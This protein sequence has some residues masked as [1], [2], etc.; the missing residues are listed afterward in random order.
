MNLDGAR[1][2][3]TGAA[4]GIGYQ[5][6]L[7][8]SSKG[9]SILL[10]DRNREML[11]KLHNEIEQKNGK[12][13]VMVADLTN[14]A[15]R[16]KVSTEAAHSFGGVDILINNAGLLNFN[17][18]ATEDPAATER[19]LN[20][21]ITAPILLTQS[22]L[23]A[24]LEQGSGQIVNIGSTFGSIGFAYFVSYSASKAAIR[25]FSE[26]LRRELTG[27]GVT[28]TYIAPR[29]TKTPLNTSIVTRMNESLGISMDSPELVAENIVQAIESDSKDVYLG[30]PESFFVRLN[31]IF[32]RLVDKSLRKQNQSI[33][34]YAQ[35]Q[36]EAG[37]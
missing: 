24:M 32:P 11:D 15:D 10:V 28:V 19:L 2:V 5:T 9:A 31:A 20:V 22:I 4:G 29:A 35:L 14:A 34:E 18:F 30:F 17:A 36:R 27:S 21:N 8:L 33:S 1:V 3:L 12:C 13:F 7:T 37:S 16:K 6:A 25:I 23:P 26:S